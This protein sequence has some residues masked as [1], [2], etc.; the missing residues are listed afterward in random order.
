MKRLI[1][2]M[3]KRLG[4][5]FVRRS[6]AAFD[7]IRSRPPEVPEECRT[8]PPDFVGIGAQKA[9]TS[10]WFNLILQ[11]PNVYFPK[12]MVGVVFP[13]FLVKERHFFD[14]FFAD[15]FND[16]RIDEYHKWFPRVEGKIAGEWTPRYM[17]DHWVVPLLKSAAP[18]AKLLVMLRDPIDRFVS[19]M[20][21]LQ[22][23]Q[24]LNP[25]HAI[26]QF[27]RGRYHEQLSEWL[28]AYSRNQIL[29]LQYELCVARPASELER[30]YRYLGIDEAWKVD[31][32]AISRRVNMT[33]PKTRFDVPTGH[34]KLLVERYSDDVEQ[35]AATYN[36]DLSLWPNFRH[37]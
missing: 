32:S 6:T 16:D 17:S 21:H 18:E 36:I 15:E 4:Y 30:T 13:H 7:V 33:R 25:N 11:H 10:W 5:D 31:R 37:L 14:R 9:G 19:G 2:Q 27:V 24:R 26:E 8:G 23:L 34:V 3:F 35:L 22:R 28:Q 20:S 29:V 12:H 1:R